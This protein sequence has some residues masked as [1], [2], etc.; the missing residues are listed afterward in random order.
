M[1]EMALAGKI[2][3]LVGSALFLI[4]EFLPYI[5]RQG[6]FKEQTFWEAA[7]RLDVIVT[8]LTVVVIALVTVSLFVPQKA[9]LWVAAGFALVALAQY[10]P[11]DAPNY[12]VFGAGMWL[13]MVGG[14]VMVVGTVLAA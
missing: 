7:V 3:A 9:L 12:D 6:S 2:T 4:V 11:T 8:V 5:E 10:A 13:G 14:I 1:S